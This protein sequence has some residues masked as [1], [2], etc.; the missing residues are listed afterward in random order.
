MT[1]DRVVKQMWIHVGR[2]DK[3]GESGRSMSRNRL[4][5]GKGRIWSVKK[6]RRFEEVWK[7]EQ[8]RG[9]ANSKQVCYNTRAKRTPE[10]QTGSR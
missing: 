9:S 10:L 6:E 5:G 3:R 2:G 4:E 8:K 7:V 1:E